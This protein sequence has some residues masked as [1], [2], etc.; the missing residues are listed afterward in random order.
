MLELRVNWM[1]YGPEGG[2]LESSESNRATGWGPRLGCPVPPRVQP[3]TFHAP[4]R[5]LA[6]RST[7]GG[8][9]SPASFFFIRA[10][11]SFFMSVIGTFLSRG[12][13]TADLVVSYP[14]SSLLC[15]SMTRGRR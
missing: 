8:F 14:I 11:T 9:Y 10:L 1:G 6:S 5:P 3:L 7:R 4:E 2:R 13:W 15:S 12:R